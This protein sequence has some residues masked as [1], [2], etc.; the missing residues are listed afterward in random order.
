MKYFYYN[1]NPKGLFTEDCTCRSISVAEG[2]TWEQCHEKLSNLSRREGVILNDASFIEN[3]LDERY[4]KLCY[5]GITI[6]DLAKT[7]P[8]GHFVATMEG[9][10]TAIIDNVIV[11]TF[12]CSNRKV[13]CCWQI[14]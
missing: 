14:M 1:A 9:H 10:I 7:L 8:K 13:K 5:K 2:I 4:P 3:Y 11:D 6:G 12:D